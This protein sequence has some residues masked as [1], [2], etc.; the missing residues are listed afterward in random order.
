VT[1]FDEGEQNHVRAALRYLRRR[2]G[3]WRPL[4]KAL[5]FTT[6]MLEK[7]SNG[8]ASVSARMAL[9]VARLVGVQVEDL[10]NGRFVPAGACPRCGYVPDFADEPTVAESVP[11]TESEGGLKLVK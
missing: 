1:D 10:I 3:G 6:W 4:S 5:G 7:V 2:T 9:R 11:R 8:R